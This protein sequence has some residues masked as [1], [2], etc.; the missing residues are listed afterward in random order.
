MNRQFKYVNSGENAKEIE[1]MLVKHKLKQI[2]VL[3][4]NGQVIDIH[5]KNDQI[6]EFLPNSI[7]IMAGGKGTRLMPYT[8]N[9]PKPMVKINGKPI[10]EIV[11]NNIK[12]SGLKNIYLSVNHFKEQIIDYFEMEAN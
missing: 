4:D 12:Q 9:I 2:P 1:K 5:S 3:N 8:K 7:V 10:L 6:M 11:I